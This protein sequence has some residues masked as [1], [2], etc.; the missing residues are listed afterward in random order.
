MSLPTRAVSHPPLT[1]SRSPRPVPR[2]GAREGRRASTLLASTARLPPAAVALLVAVLVSGCY[3]HTPEASR[4]RRAFEAEAPGL[5]LEREVGFKVGRLSLA[6]ARPLVAAALG[7]PEP[8]G[9]AAGDEGRSLASSLLRGLRRVELGVYTV[10]GAGDEA[11]RRDRELP[12]F[13]ERRFSRDDWSQLVRARDEAGTSWV[14]LRHRGDRLRSIQ[15]VAFDGSELV[16]VRLDG[17]LDRMLAEAVA[18]RSGGF[19]RELA[20]G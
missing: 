9:D 18:A 11:G 20:D 13:L 15:V 7:E 16:M 8:E 12:R 5:E 19:A 4:V 17:R 3:F 1:P 10:S 2:S 14:Y 6:I